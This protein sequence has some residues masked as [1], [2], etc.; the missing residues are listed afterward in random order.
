V[1]A[2]PRGGCGRG[3]QWTMAAPLSQED[4]A[5]LI[6]VFD[7]FCGI[8]AHKGQMDGRQFAKMTR[9][10]KI[11]DK[12]FTSI[13]VDIIF[14]K[15]K[16]KSMRR[17]DFMQFVRAVDQIAA[18]KKTGFSDLVGKLASAGGPKIGGTPRGAQVRLHD[19][20][21][22]YTGVHAKGGPVTVD[23]TRQIDFGD[24]P[25]HAAAAAAAV[26]K[27]S[28]QMQATHIGDG[29]TLHTFFSD[30]A[31]GR[32]EM[33]G[34]QFAKMAKDTKILSKRFTTIDLDIIFAKVKHKSA[35]KINFKQFEDALEMIAEKKGCA[36]EELEDRLLG[37]GG[38]VF[39]GV[40]ADKV[41][42]HDDKT[43]YTGVYTNGGPD[44]GPVTAHHD[45]ST[46]TDRSPADVR[47]VKH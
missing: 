40:K 42:L 3:P 21:A 9:D 31:G 22:G 44:T 38:P 15:V 28:A 46:L 24:P 16:D 33:D 10:T 14:A 23:S 17:I 37:H 27:M 47:G 32:T 25:P 4:E 18:L 29:Y 8:E 36:F 30:H 7:A 5:A 1:P 34:R 20:K 12:K 2:Q 19:D 41:K 43:T 35:R 39:T 45:I 26:P 11:L 13:D 6:D